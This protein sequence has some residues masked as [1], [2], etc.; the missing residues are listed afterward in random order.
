MS[1]FKLIG[2]SR[3]RQR[4]RQIL[5]GIR[6]SV[7]GF[8]EKTAAGEKK[9]HPLQN[10]GP[11]TIDE[12]LKFVDYVERAEKGEPPG[13]FLTCERK[14]DKNILKEARQAGIYQLKITLKYVRPPIWRR[15]DVPGDVPLW[16]N[17][18]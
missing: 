1:P 14:A 4:L 2:G 9:W 15:I 18:I 17:C 10:I 3:N 13:L 5:R 6:N 8:R 12:L 7:W 16:T 11:N